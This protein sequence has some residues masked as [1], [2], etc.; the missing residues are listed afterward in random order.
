MLKLISNKTLSV[1]VQEHLN[2]VQEEINTGKITAD[3]AWSNRTNN[4]SFIEIKQFLLEMT[5]GDGYCNYCEEHK[6]RDI[7]HI[8]PKAIYPH[9]AFDWNNYLL[10]CPYCNS[11][12]KRSQTAIFESPESSKVVEIKT[13]REPNPNEDF[14]FINPRIDDPFDFIALDIR[15][16]IFFEK[17]NEG[18][19]PYERANYTIKVLNL[20]IGLEKKRIESVEY[21]FQKLNYAVKVYKSSSNEDLADAINDYEPFI[22]VDDNVDVN[23]NK[24]KFLSDIKNAIL[25]ARHATVWH[26]IKIQYQ[27][28]GR[29]KKLFD[30]F[31]EALKW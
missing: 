8:H 16:G 12:V 13:V 24:L 20:N 2:K 4:Q 1:D 22:S 23:V 27:Q 28:S 10:A 18:T 25:N 29:F 7:E 31:E 6:A 11:D 9:L 30:E 14:V 17:G 26:E 5:V 21:F 15:K 3:K 19:R